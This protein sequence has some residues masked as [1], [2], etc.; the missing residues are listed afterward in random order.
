MRL[1]ISSQLAIYALLELAA[2][3]HD[4]L[5]VGEIGE[6]YGVSSHHLAKVMNIL[7]RARLVRSARGVGGGYQF[8]GNARRT[9]LLEV[10]EL[11]ETLNSSGLDGAVPGK[12]T[13]EQRALGDI[14]CEVDEIAKATLG[15]ITIATLLKMVERR[16]SS[17]PRRAS[18]A[19][20]EP[21]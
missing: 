10:I 20:A 2:R 18:P 1:Q 3:P 6:K 5:P 9:T 12:A 11:F 4:Q 19:T 14:M 7:G 16:R 17:R 13:D 21:G 8:T 15:S